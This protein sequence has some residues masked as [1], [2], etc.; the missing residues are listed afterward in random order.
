MT[1]PRIWPDAAAVTAAVIAAEGSLARAA[2]A[3]GVS[4]TYVSRRA[5]RDAIAAA[6]AAKPFASSSSLVRLGLTVI[7]DDQIR[8]A[9]RATKNVHG[10]AARML[11]M[12]K[13][14]L[15]TRWQRMHGVTRIAPDLPRVAIPG[16][17][18]RCDCYTRTEDYTTDPFTGVT[19]RRAGTCRRARTAVDTFL[20]DLDEEAA[21]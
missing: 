12:P 19:I 11:G 14:T 18:A 2:F 4:A 5:D 16:Q 8:D 17:C 13:S 21:A 1:T 15:T 3:L 10:S 6:H 7:T 9:M 20:E